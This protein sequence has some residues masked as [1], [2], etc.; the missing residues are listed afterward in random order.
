MDRGH[1][2]E[3]RARCPPH[4]RGR[5]HL[6]REWDGEGKGERDVP[7]PYYDNEAAFERV[8]ELLMASCRGLLENL[9]PKLG[10]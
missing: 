7:D 4:Y 3:L 10:K 9:R 5:I 8:Y 1:V 6:M 2:Q